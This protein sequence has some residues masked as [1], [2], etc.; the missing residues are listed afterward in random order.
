MKRILVE[1]LIDR[2]VRLVSNLAPA[3]AATSSFFFLEE[4]VAERSRPALKR[5]PLGGFKLQLLLPFTVT[6]PVTIQEISIALAPREVKLDSG[7]ELTNGNPSRLGS[8]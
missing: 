5:V 3:C 7:R 6:R 4:G 2:S 8:L 1:F